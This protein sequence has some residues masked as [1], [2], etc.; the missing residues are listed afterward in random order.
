MN[1]N[2]LIAEVFGTAV[3][4]LVSVGTAVLAAQNDFLGGSTLGVAL[5]F[6]LTL[7]A[8]A[9]A[10]GHV[11]GCHVNP[12]VTL[13]MWLTGNMDSKE[14]PG[15]MVSQVLGG[16]LG[17]AIL[18]LIA[19]G[20]DGFS[21]DN[22]VAGAFGANGYDDL[23]PGGYNLLAGLVSEIVFTMIFVFVVLGTTTKNFPAA[24]GG[25]AAGFALTIVHLV[26]IPVTNASVNP[27]R[28]IATNVFAGGD[29]I[30]Q[31]WLFIVAPLV[32]GALAAGLFRVLNPAESQ[33]RIGPL[34]PT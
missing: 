4:V 22:D 21:I 3:L 13:G 32:G 11:S 7:M 18:L 9:Y 12:A 19:N 6:G 20:V 27:A 15:Y 33:G 34:D 2:K 24:A 14:V 8:L 1:A 10:I 28:S 29:Y 16:L 25:I 30:P 23:S 5:A 26:S 17:A 31:L